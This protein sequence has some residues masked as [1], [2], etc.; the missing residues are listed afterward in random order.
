MSTAGNNEIPQHEGPNLPTDTEEPR[1]PLGLHLREQVPL[2]FKDSIKCSLSPN[3]MDVFCGC[4]LV[5]FVAI[6]HDG[7]DLCMTLAAFW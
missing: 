1:A 2:S 4:V 3:E 7:R 5:P 6:C